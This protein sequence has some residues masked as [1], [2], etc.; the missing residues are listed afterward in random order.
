LIVYF[1][2]E[3]WIKSRKLKYLGV[4][5]YVASGQ[6]DYKGVTYRFMVMERFSTDLQKVFEEAGKVF[7]KQTVYAL[8]LRMVS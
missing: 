3:D 8:A 1:S 5:R 2:V 6:H 7:S 4:P